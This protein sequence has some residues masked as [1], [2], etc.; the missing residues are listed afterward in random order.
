MT[1]ANS[2]KLVGLS[3]VDLDAFRAVN[4]KTKSLGT[5]FQTELEYMSRFV[6]QVRDTNT[7]T[8]KLVSFNRQL[9]ILSV[10]EQ[11]LVHSRYQL[12]IPYE[13]IERYYLYKSARLVVVKGQVWI[14]LMIPLTTGKV[15][16]EF[17]LFLPV[18][19]PIPALLNWETSAKF[20]RIE[21]KSAFW[22]Y[23]DNELFAVAER[24]QNELPH[25]SS[26][27]PYY[28]EFKTRSYK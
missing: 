22:M 28:L 11:H 21:E 9:E 18:F 17:K 3:N 10:V 12:G 8:N 20:V 25:H 23:K 27:L 15:G 26:S 4:Q 6:V 13:D 2:E 5:T 1:V 24:E 14:R 19:H 7:M 16:Q